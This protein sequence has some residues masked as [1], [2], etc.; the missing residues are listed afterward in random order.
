MEMMWLYLFNAS[1]LSLGS[2]LSCISIAELYSDCCNIAVHVHQH[3]RVVQQLLQQS[4]ICTSVLQLYSD[5][6]NIT[7]HV[8]EYCR[9]V[10]WLLQQSSTCTLVSELWETNSVPN[11]MN[12]WHMASV[13]Y[14][15][16]FCVV[17]SC[18]SGLMPTYSSCKLTEWPAG[19]L[20]KNLVSTTPSVVHNQKEASACFPSV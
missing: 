9:A 20:L 11:C 15:S 4:N 3:D 5:C 18:L 8:H 17:L 12:S 7:V 19:S 10:Q 13:I 1:D 16:W 14:H 6:C 2:P